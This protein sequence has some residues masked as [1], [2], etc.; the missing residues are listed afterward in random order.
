MTKHSLSPKPIRKQEDPLFNQKLDQFA[1]GAEKPRDQSVSP[2]NNGIIKKEGFK[3]F[4]LRLSEEDYNKLGYL[5]DKERISKNKI[6]LE[7]LLPAINKKL[8]L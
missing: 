3:I 7:I 2:W 5:A 8:G 6:C 4:T 1:M